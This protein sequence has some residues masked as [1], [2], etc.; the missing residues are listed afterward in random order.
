MVEGLNM[1]IHLAYNKVDAE[2]ELIPTHSSPHTYLRSKNDT[3]ITHQR[4]IIFSKAHRE[5]IILQQD[6][7]LEH[8]AQNNEEVD[9]N[10]LGKLVDQTSYI[11]VDDNL[12]PVYNFTLVDVLQKP[13]GAKE[14]RPHKKTLSTINLE[15]P[16]I[17]T[18]KLYSPE[19]LLLK[20]IFRKSYY[21]SHYD[22]VT[23]KFLFDIA[24]WLSTEGKFAE[25]EAFNIETK[26]RDAI[27]LVDGGRKY[28]R[29]FLEGIV[30]DNSYCLILHLSDQELKLPESFQ[31]EVEEEVS[32]A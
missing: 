4:F 23:F 1:R 7:L 6:N 32:E 30:K 13:D 21:I 8:L 11:T 3:P 15:I 27:V 9:I 25:L 12:E 10:L 18:N 2:L 31:D 20:Y 22:G 14:E 29:A 5:E 28:P 26:K 24:Q 19:E 17:V 16:V